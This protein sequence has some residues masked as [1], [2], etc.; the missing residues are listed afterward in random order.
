MRDRNV[1]ACPFLV[2][3]GASDLDVKPLGCFF[4]IRNVERH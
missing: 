1:I 2:S 4:Q 3:L